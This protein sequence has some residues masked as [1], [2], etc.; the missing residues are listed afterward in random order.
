MLSTPSLGITDLLAIYHQQGSK[1]MDVVLELVNDVIGTVLL[2]PKDQWKE[3]A[4]SLKELVKELRGLSAEMVKELVREVKK[5][6]AAT[7]D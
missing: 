7:E 6:R 5:R 4:W 1:D 2:Y 3:I